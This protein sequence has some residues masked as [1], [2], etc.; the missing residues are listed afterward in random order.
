MTEKSLL[1]YPSNRNIGSRQNRRLNKTN[2]S[3][4]FVLLYVKYSSYFC[5]FKKNF[6][7]WLIHINLLE[8]FSRKV[9]FSFY[10]KKFVMFFFNTVF[11]AR[12]TEKVTLSI[13]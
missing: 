12:G 5:V 8:Q 13:P 6:M 2:E 9:S 1:T 10:K 3:L 11:I 7:V 4:L